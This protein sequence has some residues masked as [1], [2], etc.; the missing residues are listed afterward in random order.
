MS[1][2]QQ[3]VSC[4]IGELCGDQCHKS[5]FT[6]AQATSIIENKYNCVKLGGYLCS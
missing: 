5:V 4:S 1:Y 3:L 2:K 6:K